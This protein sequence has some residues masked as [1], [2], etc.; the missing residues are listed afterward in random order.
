M[1]KR[2]LAVLL[3]LFVAVPALAQ[4]QASGGD[5]AVINTHTP[6]PGSTE[7]YEAARKKHMAWH[8]AQKDP[9]S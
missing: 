9:W 1:S 6:K 8:K 2:N 7:K 3:A 4:P 5:V